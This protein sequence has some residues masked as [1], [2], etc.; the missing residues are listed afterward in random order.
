MGRSSRSG[1]NTSTSPAPRDTWRGPVSVLLNDVG[2]VLVHVNDFC[3]R[4]QED[5]EKAE[6]EVQRL[7][8]QL[9]EA[10]ALSESTSVEAGA[11]EK[12]AEFRRQV[13]SDAQN[14]ISDSLMWHVQRK[15]N[16]HNNPNLEQSQKEPGQLVSEL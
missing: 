8:L 6:A 12:F 9:Q 3:I 15:A 10:V 11:E 16:I 4:Q 7:R 1:R 5:R 14:L 13:L 2:S